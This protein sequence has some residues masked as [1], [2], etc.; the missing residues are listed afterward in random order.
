MSCADPG[1]SATESGN[2]KWEGPE[3]GV[4]LAYLRNHKEA[5]GTGVKGR[6]RGYRR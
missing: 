3:A 6:W 1:N 5:D 2:S 4:Y